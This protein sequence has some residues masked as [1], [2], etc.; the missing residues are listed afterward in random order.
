MDAFNEARFRAL[1]QRLKARGDPAR[2][3]AQ[4]ASAYA[5]PRRAYHNAH[6]IA[7]CLEQLDSARAL[8]QRPDE[9][10]TAMWFHDAVYDPRAK[11]NEARSA[12][13]AVQALAEAEIANDNAERVAA[14]ILATKHDREPDG[15]DGALLLDVDLSILGREPE[16]FAA[17]DRA[18]RKEYAWVP[19]ADY[20][21]GRAAI[22]ESFLRRPVIYRTE[23]FRNRL[24][25]QARDNLQSC[26]ARLR[27]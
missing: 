26:I 16:A 24:E 11:D 17:Y 1:W 6:H 23:F 21:A 9:V 20:R 4:L 25:A 2:L 19:E 15:A 22:L 18:I 10:E 12:A 13:W 14:L 5:E 8:A 3:F 7:D 27:V